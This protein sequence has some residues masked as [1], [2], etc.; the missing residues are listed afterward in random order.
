LE[1]IFNPRSVCVIGASEKEGS[2]G[3]SIFWN[4]LSSPFGGVIYPVNARR[5]SV[6]GV[7]AY[8]DVYS[9][10]QDE[11]VDLAVICIPAPFVV[12]TVRDC[13][14][15]GIK[16]VV[17]ISAGF[18]E[19][20]A[21]G[22]E[23]AA[24]IKEIGQKFGMR[25]IG[26]N[27]LGVASGSN[28][29]NATFA[30]TYAKKG[31]LGLISQSGAIATSMLDYATRENIGFSKFASIGSMLDV[32]FSDLIEYYG[33]DPETEA[34]A[35]YMESI[36]NAKNFMASASSVALTKP[37]ILLKV[38][39]TSAGAKAAASHTGSMAGSDKVIDAAFQR[40]GVLRV[41]NVD[42]LFGVTE[43]LAKQPRPQGN[44]LC[45]VTNAG[46]PGVLACDALVENGGA[47]ADLSEET[48]A[49]LNRFL[50]EHWSH[51]NPLDILG[52]A[53]PDRY[54]QT[55]KS[56]M[57]DPN[58][59]GVL[60]ILTPQSMTHPLD[61]A[62]AIVEASQGFSKPLFCCFMG[63][64]D[65]EPGRRELARRGIPQFLF[66][67]AAAKHFSLLHKY[68][69][70]ID[71]L[72]QNA[73]LIP[74]RKAIEE[75]HI[76]KVREILTTAR[77]E[78]R[79]TLSEHESKE[80]LRL[81]GINTT[82]SK[83]ATT[84]EEAVQYADELGYPVVLKL[85]SHIVTHKQDV[86]GV[87]LNLRRK[88]DVEEAFEL[89]KGAVSKEAFLGVSVQ[90]MANIREGFEL[91]VGS[92]TDSEFGPTILFGTGGSFVEIYRDTSIALPP[93]S[94][95]I[96]QRLI[97]STNISKI[98]KG[99]RGREPVNMESL[100]RIL[101]RISRLVMDQ[102][103]HIKE[104]DINPLLASSKE[105]IA[106]DAR[107]L[108]HQVREVAPTPAIRPF[109]RQY[110]TTFR[111]NDEELNIRHVRVRDFERILPFFERVSESMKSLEIREKA[112]QYTSAF[113]E[114]KKAERENLQGRTRQ[115]YNSLRRLCIGNIEKEIVMIAEREDGRIVALTRYNRTAEPSVAEL[116][117]VI[118]P[119]YQKKGLG[120][121]MLKHLLTIG[122]IEGI[123]K[124]RS[125]VANYN[126]G[127]MRQAA[128]LGFKEIG[129]SD[130]DITYEMDLSQ[131][132]ALLGKPRGDETNE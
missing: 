105:I 116:A 3:K 9:V 26:P 33:Q 44:K 115:L 73:G 25:I 32:D 87:R 29:L 22:K 78:E 51:G 121:F 20:G 83:L 92:S 125:V 10:P 85:H 68:S 1:K 55:L 132:K 34:I 12:K 11:P 70:N 93:V 118:D 64:E 94:Y 30:N 67:D 19:A 49:E 35:I 5:S 130:E 13:A 76:I 24:E 23:W 80:I 21:E 45:I 54:N 112:L 36:G 31:R 101:V 15:C 117:V 72:F 96:A 99:Y 66:P 131:V 43:I 2:V 69:T 108:L 57:K 38:G 42:D 8:K 79:Y 48:V 100:Q 71:S 106:L 61:V 28:G 120:T 63:G 16:G 7:T 17:I 95:D 75:Q 98:L 47:L 37:I 65:V 114:M 46:G 56:V 126:E 74:N 60:V 53:Q 113:S 62:D 82:Q 58:V 81:Y 40:S 111:M 119:Q 97:E 123:K 128:K 91:I 110:T 27:C 4:L 41:S 50:P 107:V 124:M 103:E 84:V 52:D 102:Y 39:K 127:F 90:P 104:I 109:P 88:Q 129:R 89:I 6:M 18:S 14:E 59:D 86:G 122:K 77:N